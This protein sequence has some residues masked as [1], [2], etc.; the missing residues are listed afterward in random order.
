MYYKIVSIPWTNWVPHMGAWFRDPVQIIRP[1]LSRR[2]RLKPIV[3]N[4]AW[5]SQVIVFYPFLAPVNMKENL[6]AS[7]KR[8][9][10]FKALQALL[11]I[12]QSSLSSLSWTN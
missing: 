5:K 11:D 1:A 3:E 4:H 12:C 9:K 2:N 8:N 10:A 7:E 6:L